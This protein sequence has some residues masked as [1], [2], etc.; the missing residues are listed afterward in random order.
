VT[1]LKTI[2]CALV[3]ILFALVGLMIPAHLRSV[4]EATLLAAAQQT[5]STVDKISESLRAAHTGPAQQLIAAT[6]GAKLPYV[7]TINRLMEKNPRLQLIGGPDRSF[8]SFLQLAPSRRLGQDMPTAPVISILLPST[9]RAAMLQHLGDSSDANVAALLRAREIDGLEKLHPAQHPAGAPFDAAMLTL[10]TLI[11]GG[12]F[13]PAF[14]A[15]IGDI[16]SLATAGESQP[17]A[18]I[19]ALAMATLSLGRQL[20]FRSLANLASFTDAISTWA[21]M[22]TLFRAQP[23]HI[24]ELYSILH[25]EEE[26]RRVFDYLS[27]H[28]EH[29][30]GDL[31]QALGFGPGS[32]AHL[33]EIGLPIHQPAGIV[34]P[35]A[36]SLSSARPQFFTELTLASR[37]LA[38][39]LKLACLFS[40]GLFFA[41]ALG[42]LW[43]GPS[44][45][46]SQVSR[47]NPSVVA[48]NLLASCVITICLW[49]LFEPEVLKAPGPG[50]ESAPR[51]EFAVASALESLQSPVKTMQDLNQVT[52]LVLALF[53]IIQLVIY[54]FCLIKL[55]EVSKQSLSASMK[56]KLL[57]NEE[58][59]FDF[60]LYV[61]LGGTVLSLIL[62]AIGIVEASL[63]AAYASTLFGI[64]FVAMLKVLHLRPFRRRLILEAGRTAGD[65][66]DDPGLME[67]IK[68]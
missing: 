30:I 7:E 51:I 46:A 53:F 42:A 59:L 38:L 39:A 67:D 1:Y 23:E 19:E 13:N 40:S 56:L 62:V 60:G 27:E 20:D 25:Y 58:N 10:A 52:L 37:E 36:S 34:G 21:E 2:L 5:E 11:D 54:C 43:R 57:D 26:S 9:Q 24:A 47:S 35:W 28:S 15:R 44:K 41:F 49:I 18:S 3:G 64:L 31:T 50:T 48:R 33:L 17:T 61:G 4:D 14:G 45:G 12:H 65:K 63:M 66:G 29:G 8:E 6:G 55:K 68:L 16:A 32:V 22:A